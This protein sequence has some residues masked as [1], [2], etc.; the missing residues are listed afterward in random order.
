MKATFVVQHEVLSGLKYLQKTKR[1]GITVATAQE[2]IVC[3]S[4]IQLVY[5]EMVRARLLTRL[6]DRALLPPIRKKSLCMRRN[7]SIGCVPINSSIPLSD[8]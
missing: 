8:L 3:F 7:V 4:I 6:W 2:M 1:K 5:L